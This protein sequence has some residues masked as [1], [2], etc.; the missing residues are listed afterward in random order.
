MKKDI[1]DEIIEHL[2]ELQSQSKTTFIAPEIVNE[3]FSDKQNTPI[4][5]QNA[6]PSVQQAPV[7]TSFSDKAMDT[8]LEKMNFAELAATAQNCQKCPLCADRNNVVFGE[9]SQNAD[10]MFIGEAPG[11][12]EDQQG[13][14]FVGKAGEL[15]TKMI[16]AMQFSREQIYITNLVKCNPPQ[17]RNPQPDEAAVC[18]HYLKRQIELIQPKV[19]DCSLGSVP[20]KYLLNKTGISRLRG[21]WDSYNGIKLMPTFHPAYLL[22]NPNDKR[23]TWSDLKQVMQVFGKV[24]NK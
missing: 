21:K 20:L 1:F 4:P 12:D 18:M 14:P 15:L 22:R 2:Q 3:F 5:A 13:R 23:E 9:G 17:N 8:A 24:H 6:A 19:I 16:S 10:L 7:A 11:Y